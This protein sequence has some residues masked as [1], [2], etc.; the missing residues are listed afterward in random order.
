[1]D[2]FLLVDL[3][4]VVVEA[5]DL[6]PVAVRRDHLPPGQVVERGAPQ[7]GL[8]AAGVH[9]DVAADARGAG[10]GRVDGEHAAGREAASE[11]RSVTTPA[12]VRMV[13]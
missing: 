2:G 3:A 7:H 11:T 8:L 12:P 9:G 13:A 1:L 5:F 6:Q 10:R 4:E